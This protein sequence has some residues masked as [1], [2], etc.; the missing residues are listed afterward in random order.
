MEEY[1]DRMTIWNIDMGVLLYS[2][3]GFILFLCILYV[4]LEESRPQIRDF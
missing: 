4:L 3:F 1:N 2:Y